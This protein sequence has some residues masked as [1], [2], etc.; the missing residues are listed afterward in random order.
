[1]PFFKN[2]WINEVTRMLYRNQ[3]KLDILLRQMPI[4]QYMDFNL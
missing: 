4:Q 3:N 1:M 2:F